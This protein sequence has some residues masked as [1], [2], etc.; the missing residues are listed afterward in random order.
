MSQHYGLVWQAVD[1]V[2]AATITP[3]SEA[4]A[5]PLTLKDV[6]A[7][8]RSLLEN[9][10]WELEYEQRECL[11]EIKR[12]QI[13]A[14]KYLRTNQRD[15]ALMRAEAA[16]SYKSQVLRI[17]RAKNSILSNAQTISEFST[18]AT[19]TQV[20][21]SIARTMQLVST[22]PM[23]GANLKAITAQ[24]ERQANAAEVGREVLDDAVRGRDAGTDAETILKGWEQEMLMN[25]PRPP[26]G[27]G[28]GEKAPI[29][30]SSIK[31]V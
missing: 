18:M 8:N 9:A 10:K 23:S 26:G 27:G 30:S 22:G 1:A 28:G 13:D 7:R 6:V 19:I 29:L 25:A 14:A 5:K 2:K 31:I 21:T 3:E 17:E 15:L 4:L 20:M 16:A 11:K 12:A 24:L